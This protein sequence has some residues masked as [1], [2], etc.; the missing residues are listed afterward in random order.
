MQRERE[1]PARL[2]RYAEE[3]HAP[4]Q[5]GEVLD[6]ATVLKDR[7]IPLCKTIPEKPWGPPANGEKGK[8]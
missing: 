6:R 2:T 8:A 3:A 5:E 4:I 7:Y 1:R